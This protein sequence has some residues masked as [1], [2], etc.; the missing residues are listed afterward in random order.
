M[1]SWDNSVPIVRARWWPISRTVIPPAYSEM[2]ISS[3]PPA[4]REPLG[5]SRGSK[6]PIRSCGTSNRT[7]PT[8]LATV[9]GVLPLREFGE[10]RPAG[11][12]FSY[13]RCS[14][15][16]VVRPRSSTALTS[17]GRNPPDPV[18]RNPSRSTCSITGSSKPA[19][20]ISLI[21]CRAEGGSGPVGTPGV[22]SH[23]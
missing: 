15:S 6:L 19:S 20:S 13:P 21:A 16:S 9:L 7:S 3:R 23:C 14:V 11:S 5:T 4:R 10:P 2:I 17:S 8:S 18:S 1:V 12:P 22:Y